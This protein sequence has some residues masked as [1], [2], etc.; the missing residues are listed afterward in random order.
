MYRACRTCGRICRCA[1]RWCGV[2]Q[3]CTKTPI[4]VHGGSLSP[5]ERWPDASGRS[6]RTLKEH[7]LA[8]PAAGSLACSWQVAL[9]VASQASGRRSEPGVRWRTCTECRP[10]RIGTAHCIPGRLN[11]WR[12]PPN[13]S[14]PLCWKF[15]AN[16]PRRPGPA[17]TGGSCGR[18]RETGQT[19][20]CCPA[21]PSRWGPT[22]SS[23]TRLQRARPPSEGKRNAASSVLR[24]YGDGWA[25]TVCQPPGQSLTYG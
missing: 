19:S 15:E 24:H 21:A 18:H 3:N 1:Y 25:G 16:S 17:R 4:P 9:R 11:D 5:N 13:C 2:I 23:Y 8:M 22:A 20:C 12:R 6:P 10:C 14:L 7:S